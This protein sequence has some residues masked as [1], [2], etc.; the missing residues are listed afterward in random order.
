VA[1]AQ[2]VSGAVKK[3]KRAQAAEPSLT[4]WF[5]LPILSAALLFLLVSPLESA[6]SADLYAG[7]PTIPESL[8]NLAAVSLTHSGPFRHSAWIAWAVNGMHTF[9][10]R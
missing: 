9:W 2:T 10:P 3:A 5:V 4:V 1:S 8:N 6:E 7:A